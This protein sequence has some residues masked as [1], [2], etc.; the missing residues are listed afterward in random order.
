MGKS[1]LQS[2]LLEY[3]VGKIVR[4]IRKIRHKLEEEGLDL[5][6]LPKL[7]NHSLRLD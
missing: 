1:R 4:M 3:K 2:Q 7:I 6:Q 5:R